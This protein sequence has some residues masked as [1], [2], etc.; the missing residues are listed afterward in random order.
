MSHHQKDR[1]KKVESIKP[2]DLIYEPC[3]DCHGQTTPVLIKCSVCKGSGQSSCRKCGGEGFY[4]EECRSCFGSKKVACPMCAGTGHSVAA[5][6]SCGG[7]GRVRNENGYPVACPSCGGQS[8]SYR[9]STCR[10]CKG[11]GLIK[12]KTCNGSGKG[13]KRVCESCATSGLVS[14]GQCG[15]TGKVETKRQKHVP[16]ETCESTGMVKSL[17][18][19]SEVGVVC[20]QGSLVSKWLFAL[21]E[22]GSGLDWSRVATVGFGPLR[23]EMMDSLLSNKG[24]TP[25]FHGDESA[26]VLIVGRDGWT[27]QNVEDQIEARAGNSLRIYSQ[28]MAMLALLTGYDPYELDD[29]TLNEFGAGHPALEFLMKHEF[30]WPIVTQGWSD[31]HVDAEEWHNRSPLT[32]MG[33]HVGMR[34]HLTTK[35]RRSL[36]EN[37]YRGRLIFPAD[38][39]PFE[40][41]EWGCPGSKNRLEKIATH[42]AR[43]IAL[44]DSR[45]N[46]EVAVD[47]WQSDLD[48]MKDEFYQ[49]SYRFWWPA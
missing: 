31:I 48:W 13:E 24:M 30:T 37:I 27:E 32:A 17:R 20:K 8:A 21:E 19:A 28:E 9:R 3:P 40:Q 25:C 26:S 22:V 44:R 42:I 4:L 7:S 6:T 1:M 29:E 43:Q 33:Y 38:F 11:S 18:A 14:C 23:V 12:C 46:F 10:T 2:D 34:S 49:S 41:R 47:E 16:C 35:D 5:C 36:L 45:P 15:G 39:S